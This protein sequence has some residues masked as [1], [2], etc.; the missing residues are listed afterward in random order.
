M[1]TLIRFI[2]P[3]ILLVVALNYLDAYE[4]RDD[5]EMTIS[6]PGN[7][8][9]EIG[10]SH[11]A[12]PPEEGTSA[13]R[14][15]RRSSNSIQIAIS[16]FPAGSNRELSVDKDISGSTTGTLSSMAPGFET[17]QFETDYSNEVFEWV[18]EAT[19]ICSPDS[20]HLLMQYEALPAVSQSVLSCGRIMEMPKP[21]ET[22]HWL[23]GEHVYD[24]ICRMSSNIHEISHGY[25]RK[26]IF[27]YASE[28]G[29]T[30][31]M[32][33]EGRHIYI[34]PSESYLIRFP[35]EYLFP[36]SRLSKTIPEDRRTLR[37]NTYITGRTSTQVDGVLALLDELNAYYLG[38]RFR[39]E[40]LEAYKI[41]GKSTAEGFM[42]WV[43][44]AQGTMGA[45]FEMDYFIL[46]YLHYMKLNYP[47]HYSQLQSNKAFG[48]AWRAIRTYY[49]DLVAGYFQTIEEERNAINDAGEFVMRLEG[50]RLWISRTGSR[51]SA[52]R[53][54]ISSAMDKLLPV[55]NSHRYREIERDFGLITPG[56][57]IY[58]KLSAIN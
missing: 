52:N 38:S 16:I 35:G 5:Y 49:G 9:T 10:I 26:N 23:S 56:D 14:R 1:R 7:D 42:E 40:M 53:L 2:F 45:F 18:K 57:N 44:G 55:L 54:I 50:N 11:L 15:S 3:G 46:E 20:W 48:E 17:P 32:K 31:E 4:I 33:D 22:F 47:Q 29:I 24:V 19:R 58:S 28:N 13:R 30:L 12:P 39:Y 25:S 36:A 37:Y 6:G 34:S 8:R 27:R 51:S 41:S 21:A 43:S